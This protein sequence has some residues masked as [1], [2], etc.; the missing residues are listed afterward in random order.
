MEK[1]LPKQSKRLSSTVPY[2]EDF[3][4]YGDVR[5]RNKFREEIACFAGAVQP[6]MY[7]LLTAACPLYKIEITEKEKQLCKAEPLET[8]CKTSLGV[9][10]GRG[11]QA[12][13]RK[14]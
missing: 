5:A 1:H 11:F 7:I 2:T 13:K 9:G 10:G 4:S 8:S 14:W 3:L 6:Y 12:E